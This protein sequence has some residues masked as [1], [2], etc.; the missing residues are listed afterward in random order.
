MLA[1]W[2]ARNHLILFFA[3][4]FVAY[5][6]VFYGLTAPPRDT[7]LHSVIRTAVLL[8]ELGSCYWL[9][10]LLS[11]NST[12]YPAP[13]RT[14]LYLLIPFV[15]AAIY[16]AQ[17]YALYLS[18]NFITVLALENTGES[19][20]IRQ[21]GS[22]YAAIGLAIFWWL[23]FVVGYFLKS[24][25]VHLPA[26]QRKPR[27]ALRRAAGL[28][29]ALAL[30]GICLSQRDTGVLETD[31]RQSPVVDFVFTC[32][33][34]AKGLKLFGSHGSNQPG[35]DPAYPLQKTTIYDSKL[36]FQ[37]IEN[38]S[39]MNLVVIFTEGTSARLVGAYG[40]KYPGLTPNIDRLASRSMRVMN[41]YNH[42]AATYRGLQGQLV[43][44]YPSTGGEDGDD[45]D[46]SATLKTTSR[47]TTYQSLPRILNG[48]N[49]KTFFLSPH[50]DSVGLNTLLRLL[51]FDR[52]FSFEDVSQ[53]IAPGNKFYFFEGALSDGDIFNALQIL[54]AKK[55]IALADHPFFIGTYNFG[56]H[57][58]LD[59]MSNGIK[60]GDGSNPVLNRLHNYD[61]ELGKF[62]DYFFSSAYSKNTI[63][64]LT[65]D[66]A[67]FP[68]QPYRA[69]AGDH[70]IPVFV[71]RIPLL[72]YDPGHKL[73]T[74][75]N[76]GGRT[77]I[78]LAPTLLQ[79]L[80]VNNVKNSFE[81]LSLFEK[82]PSAIGFAAIGNEFY[83]T[84][85]LGVY[86]EDTVPDKYKKPFNEYKKRVQYYYQLEK[87]DR[88]FDPT[89]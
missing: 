3:G 51:G 4:L 44:G 88:I 32:I 59:V 54:L 87:A 26:V 50:H 34:S 74:V 22:V 71:D 67:D 82:P 68:D 66:H 47:V 9:C 30:T 84:D 40:G 37:R 62:L 24:R 39:A 48:R 18:G 56:T 55:T 73:P 43:S 8:T 41:Y 36:P 23:L 13:F 20:I 53:N 60:Y 61:F 15:L 11:I 46:P 64:V 81:G 7:L 14:F 79:L 1:S 12:E 6:A 52:V 63:L 49:Y 42:T 86:P 33:K 57:A 5:L 21:G 27:S 29:L 85:A 65:S 17:T 45:L 78:D 75:F 80:D 72:V 35:K 83:A 16:T 77:S 31:Y 70:Y 38:H 19:R 25:K 76:A 69:L 10:Q 58:F 28:I 89:R 2:L